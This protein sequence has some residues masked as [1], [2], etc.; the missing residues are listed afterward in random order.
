MCA[1]VLLN[2]LHRLRKSDK[3]CCS[4]DQITAFCQ[5]FE[6]NHIGTLMLDSIYHMKVTELC[7]CV[8]CANDISYIKRYNRMTKFINIVNP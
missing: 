3:M 1:H 7:N 4:D 6:T 8:I 5:D 2:L